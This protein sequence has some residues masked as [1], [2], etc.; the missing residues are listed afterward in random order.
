MSR[1]IIIKC[2]HKFVDR[3]RA[4]GL[5]RCNDWA[6]NAVVELAPD[7]LLDVGCG[8]GGFLFRYLR[9]SPREFWGVEGAP[10]LKLL[11]EQRGIKV[12]S[13]DLNG[14][15][16][17][18]DNQFDVVF[19]SQVIEHLHN[20]RLFIEESHRVL[21]PGGTA[22]ITSENLCSLLNLGAMALG[23]TPFSLMQ[24]CGRFLGNPLGLH[25][26]EPI[27]EPLPIDHPAFSGVS[28][29]VRVLTVRQAQELFQL[30][31]FDGEVRS[32]GMLPLP[33]ALSRM[34]EKFIKSR[35]HFLLVRARKPKKL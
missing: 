28:G 7:S 4:L 19:S 17:F 35:G 3:Q 6:G 29:H 16:P 1:N 18:A 32:I 2:L 12:F 23:Y 11:A 14:R 8:D 13:F 25:Y 9:Q 21:K 31:G 34:L 5:E 22:I 30:A 10:P 33:D 26:N 27:A 24:V 20:T 15:W